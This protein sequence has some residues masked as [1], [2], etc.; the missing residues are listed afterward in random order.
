MRDDDD[1]DEVWN[2]RG[3]VD[4]VV[5]EFVDGGLSWLSNSADDGLIS[6]VVEAPL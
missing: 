3:V 5:I 6:G 4:V 2:G 1:V